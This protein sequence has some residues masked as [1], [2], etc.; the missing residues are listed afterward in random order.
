MAL[1]QS[2]AAL[3]AIKADIRAAIASKQSYVAPG[4]HFADYAGIIRQWWPPEIPLSEQYCFVKQEITSYSK[5]VTMYFN[6]AAS[7]GQTSC[8]ARIAWGDGNI[9]SFT[10]AGDVVASHTYEN[11]GIYGI[12]L[13]PGL[14]SKVTLHGRPNSGGF[15][16]VN[17]S[18]PDYVAVGP[19]I[20][21]GEAALTLSATK[22]TMVV[23]VQLPSTL[24]S[25]GARALSYYGPVMVVH[26][27]LYSTSEGLFRS[28]PIKA[29]PV[30]GY[31]IT[32]IADS[33]F[34]GCKHME[35]VTNEGQWP[36][37]LTRI[38][39]YAFGDCYLL[40]S[41]SLPTS[42]TE[43]G[44]YAF[45]GCTKLRNLTCKA[46]TPPTL[47]YGAFNECLSLEHIYVP[48]ASLAAYQVATNWS[49]YA[50]LMVGV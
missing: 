34:Y 4:T 11:A 47:G 3:A 49:Q 14:T 50:S 21:L 17:G 7:G 24:A 30:L 8:E 6:L 15:L 33:A 9:E 22:P 19:G 27:T 36:T 41:V 16:D 13:Y 42:V 32:E 37:T 46:T 40:Q 29:V 38:G 20:Y 2:I 12:S 5:T 43:I 26:G 45:S 25:Y 1:E 48:A 18:A 31:G 23:D 28:S 44:A 10:E 35:A 39:Y